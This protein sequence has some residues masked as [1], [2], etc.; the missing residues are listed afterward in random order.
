MSLYNT[1]GIQAGATADEIKQAY[2]KRARE[3]HPDRG[4]DK[5]RFQEIEEAYRILSDKAKRAQ[6]DSTGSTK[7]QADPQQKARNMIATLFSKL[8][9]ANGFEQRDYVSLI[10]Q[11]VEQ[12]ERK[13]HRDKQ[14]CKSFV[15]R[16]DKLIEVT[17]GEI[18][19]GVLNQ[20]LSVAQGQIA[21]ADA[22]LETIKHVQDM[23]EQCRCGSD[24]DAC[25]AGHPSREDV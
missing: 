22:T 11:S 2:R 23:L 10:K 15:N 12:N 17:E 25:I 7:R 1:L 8:L 3:H 13:Q 19:L 9:Q 4:G 16:V 20:R 21:S 5:D 6:Y 14:K 18:L 24:V